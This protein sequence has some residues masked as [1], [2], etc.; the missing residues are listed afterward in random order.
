M[1]V[2]DIIVFTITSNCEEDTVPFPFTETET[3]NELGR[4]SESGEQLIKK[5]KKN[6]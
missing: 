6:K 3:S 2:I 1:A 4:F 5:R